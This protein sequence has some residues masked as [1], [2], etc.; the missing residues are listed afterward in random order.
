MI[1]AND[2][3]VRRLEYDTKSQNER[4]IETKRIQ[5]MVLSSNYAVIYH[6]LICGIPKKS[7]NWVFHEIS[8][9]IWYMDKAE[10]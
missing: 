8:I 2:D 7:T 6:R 9:A 3:P 5:I 10:F 1:W 4:Q